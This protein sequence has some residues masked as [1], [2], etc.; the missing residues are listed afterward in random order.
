MEETMRQPARGEVVNTLGRLFVRAI[1]LYRGVTL[2]S[3]D[4]QSLNDPI[5]VRR[6]GY[7]RAI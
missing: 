5:T 2:D 7:R 6:E 3:V 1:G 4:D